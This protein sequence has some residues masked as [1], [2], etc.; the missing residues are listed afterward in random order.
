MKSRQR[1]LSIIDLMIGAAI[2]LIGMLAVA[3]VMVNF[4]RQRNTTSQTMEAQANGAMALYLLQRS[5][6]QAG[7]GMMSLQACPWINWYYGGTGRGADPYGAAANPALT[8]LPV[9]ITDGGNASDTIEVQYGTARSGV[10]PVMVTRTQTGSYGDAIVIASISGLAENDLFVS[11]VG[12]SCTLGRVSPN[13]VVA[14]P[15]SFTHTGGDYNVAARPTGLTSGWDPVVVDT[16]FVANLGPTL[17]GGRYRIA[18]DVLEVAEFPIYVFNP[19]VD[20]IVFMKAEYG[21]DDNN[22]GA[23]DRWVKGTAADTVTNV[24]AGRVVAIRVGVVA[25]SPLYEREEILDAPTVLSVLP[26]IAN[27]STAETTYTVPD[28]HFRYKTYYTII[29]LR[30]VIWGR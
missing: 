10:P 25:R 19:L 15:P 24:N 18:S 17:G 12:T 11:V 16:S 3:Q 20:G 1:G 21:F 14:S 4:N 2:A 7:Y 29:P 13:G 27:P 30:N 6:G 5:L 22:D 9:R 23:V 28:R 26:A 8:T